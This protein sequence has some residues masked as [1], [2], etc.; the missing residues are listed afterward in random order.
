[1][2]R[3]NILQKVWDHLVTQKFK[4]CV[5]KEGLCVY[6]NNGD[7]CAIGAIIPDHLYDKSME[8]TGAFTMINNHDEFRKYLEIPSGTP[9]M[10]DMNWLNELQ[11]CHDKAADDQHMQG[12]FRDFA[13]KYDLTLNDHE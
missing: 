10:S 5:D 9:G 12:R 6:K 1:M 8:G 13:L 3:K 11:Y 4:R 2:N 7:R